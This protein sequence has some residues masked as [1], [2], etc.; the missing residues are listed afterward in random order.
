MS[1][2]NNCPDRLDAP[3]RTGTPI[4]VRVEPDP[5]V[6][7][8]KALRR[9][10]EEALLGLAG[11]REYEATYYDGGRTTSK[12]KRAEATAQRAYRRLLHDI[13]WQPRSYPVEGV[14]GDE[15]LWAALAHGSFLL[16]ALTAVVASGWAVL[17]LVF[18]PLLIYAGFRDRSRFVAFHA[19]QAFAAQVVGTIGWVVILIIGTLIFAVAIALAAVASIVLIGIPFLLLFIVL[20]VVFA[21]AMLLLPLAIVILSIAGAVNTY[22]GRDFR[23]PVI[24]GWIERQT[25]MLAY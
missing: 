16:T 25:G 10:E 5:R 9:A 11:A 7:A 23:Y 20:Y 15:R 8:R 24:A 17:A 21:L 1:E 4:P 6:A 3:P 19:L 13:D 18:V 14:T 22:S 12:R 2:H